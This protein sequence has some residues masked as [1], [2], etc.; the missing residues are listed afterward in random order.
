[1]KEFS[2]YAVGISVG[3]WLGFILFW[4]SPSDKQ[5]IRAEGAVEIY[6]GRAVCEKALDQWVCSMPKE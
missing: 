3:L 1:M 6:E 4:S 5:H 2:P